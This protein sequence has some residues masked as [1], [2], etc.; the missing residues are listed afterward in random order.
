MNSL[1][2]VGQSSDTEGGSQMLA[3]YQ[4]IAAVDTWNYTKSTVGG[5]S[6]RGKL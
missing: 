4:A 3:A 5:E 6:V 1:F 2:L